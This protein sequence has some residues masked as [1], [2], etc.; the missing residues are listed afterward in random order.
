M[1]TVYI[2]LSA[3]LEQWA[4]DTVIAMADG[5][6]TVLIVPATVK[7]AARDWLKEE[8]RHSRQEA[9]YLYRLLA[10]L[11][12]LIVW[13]ELDT[14]DGIVIDDDYPGPGPAAAIKNELIPLLKRQRQSFMGRQVFFQRVK[15]LRADRLA[16]RVFLSKQREGRVITLQEIQEMW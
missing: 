5:G 4:A 8:D 15:G 11:V 16:R 9:V 2:D 14:I 12:S 13:P 1:R 6:E 7:R 10:V 3:K